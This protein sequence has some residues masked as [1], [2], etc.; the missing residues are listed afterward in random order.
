MLLAQ[1]AEEGW[2]LFFEHDPQVAACTV[3]EDQGEVVVN[4]VVKV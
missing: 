1:A 3:K 2:V 4:E